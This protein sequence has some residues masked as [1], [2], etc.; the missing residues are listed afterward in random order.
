MRAQYDTVIVGA[1]SAGCVIAARMTESDAHD[2][3][4]VEAGPDHGAHRPADLADGTRNSYGQHDWGYLHRPS[5]RAAFSVPL[6]RGR[7]VGGSSAVN[8]CIALRGVPADYDEWA[9]RGLPA[10][11]WERCR[12]ALLRLERDL[13]CAESV[14]AGDGRFDP[15]EHGLDGPLPI[16]RARE[17]ELTG[18]QRAFRDACVER[19]FPRVEDHNAQ[20]ALGVGPH[21]RNV[22]D[23]VRQDAARAWLTPAVRA[24][25]QLAIAP[26]TSVHR[27]VFRG[28]RV[29]G[30]ELEQHGIVRTVGARR[31]VLAAGALGT[32]GLLLRSGVGPRAELTRLGVRCVRDVPAV[33]ARLLDHPGTAIFFWPAR[34]GIADPSASLVQIALRLR[35]AQGAFDGDLQL[36]PGSFWHFPLGRGVAMAGTTLMLQVGKP[37][38]TGTVRWPS[39]HPHAAPWIASRFFTEPADRAVALEGLELARD[40]LDAPSLRGLAHAVWPRPG[41]LRDRAALEAMLPSLCDS[42]YHPSGTV[43]MGEACDAFGRIAD[44]EGLH[45]ADASLFPTIP[46]ANIHLA[47]LMIGERFGAWLRDGTE[48]EAH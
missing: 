48:P 17:D 11:S 44:L 36:Q 12:P 20:G 4:L 13:D 39:R 26:H 47:V 18:W 25:P 32:P 9:A 42:G 22:V 21:P 15:G 23:G 45:V 33:G 38:G 10:W 37:V 5:A 2:V 46:T 27:L 8:T 40:L 43:P 16:R 7:V 19:G 1:G 29:A 3:L 34:G 6:P 24:R 35:S 28:R 14:A 31:V 30:V 41:R